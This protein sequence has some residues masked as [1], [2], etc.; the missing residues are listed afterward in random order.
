MLPDGR[1]GYPHLF[2]PHPRNRG[3]DWLAL[4]AY[5]EG[6]SGSADDFNVFVKAN[7][8]FDTAWINGRFA[9]SDRL[10]Q[11]MEGVAGGPV[12]FRPIWVND[13]PFWIMVVRHVVEALDLALSEY[14]PSV[15]GGVKLLNDPG[16]RADRL[17]DPSLFTV[18]ALPKT[19][20]AT[21]G[22]VRAYEESGCDGLLFSP[23]GR[24]IE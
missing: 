15:D 17:V 23:R 12:E 3:V 16:W 5:A 11:V 19:I 6:G 13:R 20:W 8:E 18:P 21:S 24:V 4:D 7:H 14:E 1:E 10:R 9:F 22:V 2:L